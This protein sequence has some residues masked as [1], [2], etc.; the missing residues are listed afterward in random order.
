[1]K[2]Y[3]FGIL[4]IIFSL[5]LHARE[6]YSLNNDWKFFFNETAPEGMIPVTL[7]HTW[8]GQDVL[9]RG[10]NYYR[11]TGNYLKVFTAPAEWKGKRVFLKFD[12]AATESTLHINNRY[13]GGHKGGNSAFVF[14]ISQFLNL[15]QN[16]T[17]A[18]TVNNAPSLDILPTSTFSNIY[19]GL[20]RGAEII[21]TDPIAISPLDYGSSGVYVMPT[22]VS[23]ERAEGK[24]TVK[25]DA[26]K[27]F[28][29]QTIH[30]RLTLFTTAYDTLRLDSVTLQGVLKIDTVATSSARLRIDNSNTTTASVPFEVENPTL[31][32]GVKNPFLYHVGVKLVGNDGTVYDSLVVKT[33]FR[34]FD[35]VDN[36]AL[37]NGEPYPVRGV[38]MYR[39]RA[40]VG[41]AVRP[42][43]LEQDLDIIAEMGANAVRIA[44]GPYNEEFYAMCDQRGLLVW[45][46]IPMIGT[47]NINDRGFID[48]DN[49]KENG[50]RQLKEMIYQLYNH[51]SV[52]MWGLFSELAV[53]GNDPTPYIAELNALAKQMDPSRKTV[54]ASNSDGNINFITDLIVWNQALG[55]KEGYPADVLVW[56]DHLKSN[57]NTL[58]SGISYA[59]GGSTYHQDTAEQLNRPS[60]Q[61]SW[62]PERW[63][64]HFHEEYLKNTRAG[65]DSSMFW[66]AF[67][68]NIFDYGANGYTVGDRCGV[69]DTGLV[70]YDR[71]YRADAYYL[72][73]ANWNREEPFVYLTE[74]RRNVRGEKVQTIKA[75]SNQPTV[76]L[77][78]NGASMGVRQGETGIFKWE[79][80]ALNMDSNV[81]EVRSG[82]LSDRAVIRGDKILGVA[83]SPDP[84]K[85]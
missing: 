32:N 47:P 50:R 54:A 40:L 78:V 25:I 83:A 36:R 6:V 75:Y 9:G 66:G 45:T 29:G 69:N 46:E 27:E 2:H 18:V 12:A 77:F 7:P 33:G 68:G 41:S 5:Q 15:G 81:V 21:V 38:V 84:R 24:V 1:M 55:W 63:Q 42:F 82:G 56:M 20:H 14:E 13:V 64:T 85:K 37:L 62:H 3:L 51:P 52:V 60:P 39:D 72:Y 80:I 19:G 48:S 35:I 10:R 58:R 28:A 34:T 79:G 8:N 43:Q 59:A 57:W 26:A 31:W 22:N 65:S 11:G 16:N 49:F 53:R 71:S 23:P 61:G 17:I 30:T 73:K 74:K 76:E 44:E 70:A 4:A 67:V